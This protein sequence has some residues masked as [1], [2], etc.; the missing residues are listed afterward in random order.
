MLTSISI[1]YFHAD[2][3]SSHWATLGGARS[4]FHLAANDGFR[5]LIFLPP[6]TS[7]N[8]FLETELF[9]LEGIVSGLNHCSTIE[10]PSSKAHQDF[11]GF[12]SLP[13][14]HQ[15]NVFKLFEATLF[16]EH[17]FLKVGVRLKI[18][19]NAHFVDIHRQN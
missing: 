7:T 4:S 8:V 2:A 5:F 16:Q 11:G 18:K 1:P 6:A 9:I 14:S 15:S 10:D 12:N 19:G 3:R 13:E 17:S